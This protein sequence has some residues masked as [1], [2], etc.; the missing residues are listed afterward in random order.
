MFEICPKLDSTICFRV[1]AL[2]TGLV[3]EADEMGADR[4]LKQ[5]YTSNQNWAV[6]KM[7]QSYE[8]DPKLAYIHGFDAGIDLLCSKAR[9]SNPELAESIR[10]LADKMA[11]ETAETLRSMRGEKK[12]LII[13][14][15]VDGKQFY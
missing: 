12:V 14:L 11:E 9:L 15:A 4:D 1:P 6:M 3:T 5:E 13:S 8:S 7:I 10:S 2:H